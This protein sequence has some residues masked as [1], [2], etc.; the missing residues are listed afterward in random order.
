[1]LQNVHKQ[2]TIFNKNVNVLTNS[3]GSRHTAS[4]GNDLETVINQICRA[5]SNYCIR[6]T[7]TDRIK[8]G[9]GGGG[10]IFKN[11][12]EQVI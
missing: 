7:Y 5:V 11:N 2:N 8:S 12:K 9:G 6:Y 1:M 10:I 3:I 4:W